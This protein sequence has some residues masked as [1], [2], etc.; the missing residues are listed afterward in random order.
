V[1]RGDLDDLDTLRAGAASCDGSACRD[2]VVLQADCCV[3]GRDPRG[4][5]NLE[6]FGPIFREQVAFRD[7]ED[8]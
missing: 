6:D 1:L 4:F 2:G 7:R 5:H 3:T 8:F